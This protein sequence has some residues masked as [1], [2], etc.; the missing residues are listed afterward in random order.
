MFQ[1]LQMI[2]GLHPQLLDPIVDNEEEGLIG[3]FKSGSERLAKAIENAVEDDMPEDLL[4]KVKNI[5]GFDDTQGCLSGAKSAYAQ[6]VP[7]S[8][9]N[10]LDNFAS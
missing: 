10:I 7:Y 2:M 6:K 8:P 4:E 9:I 5:L 1:V 3:A